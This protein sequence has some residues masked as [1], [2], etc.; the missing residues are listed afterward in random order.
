MNRQVS[1]TRCTYIHVLRSACQ[2]VPDNV[3]VTDLTHGVNDPNKTTIWPDA[4]A[5]LTTQHCCVAMLVR[6][7]ELVAG[8]AQQAM[9]SQHNMVLRSNDESRSTDA[10]AVKLETDID[11][12]GLILIWMDEGNR[13]LGFYTVLM[14]MVP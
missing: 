7:S 12:S 4:C 9:Y 13:I 6:T 14:L 3:A 8:M 11:M 5:L 10:Q 2:F 1:P